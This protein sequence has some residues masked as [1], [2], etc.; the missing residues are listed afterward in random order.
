MKSKSM[1]MCLSFVL[2]LGASLPALAESG[3]KVIKIGIVAP[4]GSVWCRTFDQLSARLLKESDGK[5]RLHWYPGGVQGDERDVVRKMRTGQLQGGAFTHTGLS[6][7]NPKVMVLQ[8]PAL[9]DSLD[10]VDNVHKALKREIAQ[11]FR[12]KGYV[13]LGWA[14]VGF[15]HLFSKNP[16]RNLK[17]LRKQKVWAWAD[18]QAT[19]ALARELGESPRLL[20]LPQVYPSLSTGMIDAVIAS[21]IALMTMQW[22]SFVKHMSTQ[23]LYYT[24]RN[25]LTC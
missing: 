5:V 23:P 4:K 25:Q 13:L 21:P 19:K 7:I 14:D 10:Q 22:Q 2:A 6:L 20:A 16:V 18:D 11:S 24:K 9:F 12:D 15:F 3:Q 8:M 1:A 17:D